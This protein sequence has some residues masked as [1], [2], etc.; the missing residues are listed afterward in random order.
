MIRSA[1]S[2]PF[3]LTLATSGQLD[4]PEMSFWVTRSTKTPN[5][6]VYGGVFTLGG[7]NSSLY[8][9]T[10]EFIALVKSSWWL[11]RLTGGFPIPLL[12]DDCVIDSG[13]KR[14]DGPREEGP[15]SHWSVC[16]RSH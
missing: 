13:M 5:E 7:T 6:D 8:T 15:C 16:L 14:C 4:S 12:L 11:L 9:G 10:I 1:G 3:W 2:T